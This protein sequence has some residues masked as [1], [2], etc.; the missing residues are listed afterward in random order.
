[1]ENF[2]EFFCELFAYWIMDKLNEPAK[3]WFEDLIRQNEKELANEI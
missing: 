1:L 3:S 2:I